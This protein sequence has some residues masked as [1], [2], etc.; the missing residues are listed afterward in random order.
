MARARQIGSNFFFFL[1]ELY[2]N[3]ILVL[4]GFESCQKSSFQKLISWN[5]MWVFYSKLGLTIHSD[6]KAQLCCVDHAYWSDDGNLLLCPVLCWTKR[7]KRA[8]AEGE[9][10]NG[11]CSS[12]G[13]EDGDAAWRAA[14][15]SIAQTTTYVSS[16]TKH[17]PPNDDDDD[18]SKPKTQQLKHYQIKVSLS[19]S[20]FSVYRL[21]WVWVYWSCQ[22]MFLKINKKNLNFPF[23]LMNTWP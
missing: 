16:T 4:L 9:P 21:V 13:E 5:K 2:R 22:L 23:T 17:G 8:M 14:I 19:I 11:Y 18:Y 1:K 20:Q 6:V 15:H 3:L 10:T 7:W 12:S